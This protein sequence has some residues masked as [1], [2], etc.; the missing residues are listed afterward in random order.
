VIVPSSDELF[1]KFIAAILAT[2]LLVVMIYVILARARTENQPRKC[3]N[4]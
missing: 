4:K 3:E 2:I 1:A